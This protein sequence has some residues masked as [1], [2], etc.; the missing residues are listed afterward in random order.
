[1]GK[2]V[3]KSLFGRFMNQNFFVSKNS[4]KPCRYSDSPTNPASDGVTQI[5]ETVS[6]LLDVWFN[7]GWGRRKIAKLDF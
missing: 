6:V 4:R 3:K 1:M 5:P 2:T 7:R